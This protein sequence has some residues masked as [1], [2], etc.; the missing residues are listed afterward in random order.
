MFLN[1]DGRSN[2]Y[3][4]DSFSLR[5]DLRLA[6]CNVGFVNPPYSDEVYAEIDFVELMLDSLLPNSIGVA[7]VPVNSVS[8]RTK[9]HSGLEKIKRR[10]LSKHRLIASIQMPGQLFYPKGTETII[11]VFET[12][13]THE[14]GTWFATFDDG[15]KLIKHQKMRT[16]T[17]ESITKY[18]E[19]LTAYKS[20]STT[21]F[22]FNKEISSED[23]WVYTLHKE[24]QY[25]LSTNDYQKTVN[26]YFAYLVQHR[27]FS[28]GSK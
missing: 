22:S 1:K 15:Y 27:Y 14:G 18:D 7:I 28:G 26:D 12:A 9:K 23:Q 21:S 5:E 17:K 19:L 11:L 16:P 2:L 20:K 3:N 4:D 6:N 25:S 10:I 8:S 13:K 24:I